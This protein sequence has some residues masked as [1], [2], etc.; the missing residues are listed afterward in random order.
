MLR[1]ISFSDTNYNAREKLQNP[2]QI[3]VLSIHVAQYGRLLEMEPT[4]YVNIN[5]YY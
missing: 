3:K 4:L 2:K 1:L 5:S